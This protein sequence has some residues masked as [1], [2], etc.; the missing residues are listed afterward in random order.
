E[1]GRRTGGSARVVADHAVT[2]DM[3]RRM[4]LILVGTPESNALL[5]RW[6]GK[7]PV[8]WEDDATILNGKA[9]RYEKFGV[10]VAMANP[11]GAGPT[12]GVCT[13]LQERI[14]DAPRS[15]VTAAA[16]AY[17]VQAVTHRVEM[18]ALGAPR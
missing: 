9:Y 11:A 16:D 17:V 10:A 12:L 4:N 8:R 7:L 13:A 14:A 6:A 15:L 3:V 1:W 5:R 2:D 18:Q